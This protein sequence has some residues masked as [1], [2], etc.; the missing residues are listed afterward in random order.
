MLCQ[1]IH[2][3]LGHGTCLHNLWESQYLNVLSDS[4]SHHYCPAALS[5]GRRR[6]DSSRRCCRHG[7]ENKLLLLNVHSCPF[8]VLSIQDKMMGTLNMQEQYF[9]WNYYQIVGRRAEPKRS[10]APL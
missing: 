5:P 4:D 8:K 9:F 2:P 7:E 10:Q 6:D 1:Q 3:P